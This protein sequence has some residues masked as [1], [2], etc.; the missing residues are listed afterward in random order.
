MSEKPLFNA[1]SSHKIDLLKQ[2]ALVQTDEHYLEF[3]AQVNG[4]GYINDSKSIRL[5]ETQD[6]LK[7]IDA[8]I[9]LIVGGE[10]DGDNDYG[11]LAK[12]IREKV[13]AIIYMGRDSDA[14]LQHFSTHSMLFAKAS[15]IEEAVQMAYFF[16]GNKE[17]VLF[18]PGCDHSFDYKVRG[19]K[20][21]K[22]VKKLPGSS[23]E[24]LA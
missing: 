1:T 11:T 4:V 12:Q 2:R 22:E 6:A 7:R 19:Y 18:S 10:N 16:S 3:V 5:K 14:I 9:V 13:S 8:S 24:A 21:K 15:T 23:A 17:V 20:F